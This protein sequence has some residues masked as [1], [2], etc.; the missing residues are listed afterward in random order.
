MR[1]S[2]RIFWLLAVSGCLW[3]S[4]SWAYFIPAGLGVRPAG[5]GE[6]FVA[7]ADDTNALLYNPAGLAR[8][9][10]I[11]LMGMYA[12]LYTH[13][14]AELYSGQHAEFGYNYLALSAPVSLLA[15]TVGAGWLQ[16]NTSFYHENTFILG[17]GKDLRIPYLSD[18]GV[19]LKG[20]LSLKALGWNVDANEYTG[21]PAL[22]PSQQQGKWNGTADIGL[23]ASAGENLYFGFSVE[24]VIPADMG[25]MMPEPL[26]PVFRAGGAYTLKFQTHWIEELAMAVEVME[27]DDLSSD[28]FTPKAGMEA[29]FFRDLIAVRAGTTS[30]QASAGLGFA[31]QRPEAPIGVQLDYAFAWPY[32]ILGTDG[33][34]RLGLTLRWNSQYMDVQANSITAMKAQALQALQDAQA[35]AE[36]GERKTLAVNRTETAAKEADTAAREADSFRQQAEQAARDAEANYSLEAKMETAKQAAEARRC[37]LEAQTAASLA[38]SCTAFLTAAGPQVAA[39]EAEQ[40]AQAAETQAAAARQAAEGAKSA[41]DAAEAA[42]YLVGETDPQTISLGVE[43]GVYSDFSEQQDIK[44]AIQRVRE[45]L[46]QAVKM[47]L[48]IREYSQEG[49]IRAF[50]QGRVDMLVSY[51]DYFEPL[52]KHGALRPMLTIQRQG[53]SLQRCCILVP[54]NGPVRQVSDLAHKRVGY[55]APEVMRHFAATF[56]GDRQALL[57]DIKL[58]KRKNALDALMALQMNQVDA[59]VDYDYILKVLARTQ[60]TLPAKVRVLARGPEV[61]YAA[62]AG[63][64]S[65]SAAKNS[66]I[67][68]AVNALA[69]LHQTPEFRELLK[70]FAIDRLV[71]AGNAKGAAET[72]PPGQ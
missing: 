54:E 66:Q 51:S 16:F 67:R 70:M 8:I 64:N 55:I 22:F 2:G 44:A 31:Y 15:G 26:K 71:P 50:Q 17:Y 23:L 28:R 38:N 49:L 13:L 24:N 52:L 57:A 46:A 45:Y 7:V 32:R 39:A 35:K 63:K 25:L 42:K 69:N 37:A 19:K 61:P 12:S 4:G 10:Q 60:R 33:S 72:N 20:G 65:R 27:R 11:E 6:A 58:E 34:H 9:E 68:Q 59:V 5:M 1:H 41:A 53:T 62:L 18:W 36:L 14:D 48:E 29:R 47:P 21:D 40:Q 43:S 56:L 3:S 30:E